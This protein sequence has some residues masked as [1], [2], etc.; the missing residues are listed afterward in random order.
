M[1]WATVEL[2][3]AGRKVTTRF[4]A[5]NALAQAAGAQQIAVRVMGSCI[6]LT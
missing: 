1:A 2:R 4:N 3:E 6:G 5:G